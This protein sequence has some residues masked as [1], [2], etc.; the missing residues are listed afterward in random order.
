MVSPPNV[1]AAFGYFAAVGTKEL[2]TQ[3]SSED[4]CPELSPEAPCPI[5][6][7]AKPFVPNNEIN[8]S[9]KNNCV[10][11]A[12]W[13]VFF[14]DPLGWGFGDLTVDLGGDP[15]LQSVGQNSFVNTDVDILFVPPSA[16]DGPYLGSTASVPSNQI[17]AQHNFWGDNGPNP[18]EALVV[19]LNGLLGTP[20]N[21]ELPDTSDFLLT[22][23]CDESINVCGE[24]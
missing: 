1:N 18:F 14:N 4:P 23:P 24:Q 20:G 10:K 21:P 22:D 13:G 7:Y 6:D 9:Y 8:I 15:E 16:A 3:L 11:T 12:R 2:A 19:D 5:Y 17:Y